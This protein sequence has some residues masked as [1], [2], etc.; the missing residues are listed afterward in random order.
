MLSCNFNIYQNLEGFYIKNDLLFHIGK[1][2]FQFFSH[3]SVICYY[4][5]II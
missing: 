1:T 3:D 2:N 5:N 4:L